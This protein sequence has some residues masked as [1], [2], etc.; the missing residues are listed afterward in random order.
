MPANILAPNLIYFFFL[1]M[2]RYFGIFL[3]T[4]IFSSIVVLRQVKI[5]L[6]L[7]MA[8][9]TFLLTYQTAN[10]AAPTNDLTVIIFIIKELSIGLFMG[11][12]IYLFFAAIQL[13]GQ[14]IDLRM[15]F[16]I[17][18]VVDPMS[19]ASSPIIG[20]FKNIFTILIFLSINGHLMIIRSLNKSFNIIPI[21]EIT[22]S[23]T[24]WQFLFR[25]SADLFIIGFKIALPIMGTLFIVDI[26]L[27][28]LA[29]A[30]PQMNIFIIGLPLKILIGFILLILS[31][32]ILI[33]YFSDI[34]NN[35]LDQLIQLINIMGS[36]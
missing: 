26:M 22:Y 32:E 19:G 36:T 3:I 23:N 34:L 31:F 10:I 6:A 35:G 27:G 11:F 8:L 15:G 25:R 12:I 14:F 16:R 9:I 5:I 29:R 21:G 7:L 24:L 1:I 30:V 17:A 13:A 28:F 4:P 20:Q 18:N 33:Y 2:A